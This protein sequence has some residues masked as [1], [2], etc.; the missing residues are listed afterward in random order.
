MNFQKSFEGH[1]GTSRCEAICE[2]V[3]CDIFV[4][5]EEFSLDPLSLQCRPNA[6]S[7]NLVRSIQMQRSCTAFAVGKRRVHRTEWCAVES[8]E[9]MQAEVYEAVQR[10]GVC[11]VESV[12][13]APR[14]QD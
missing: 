13:E 11:S 12:L 9:Q 5:E 3:S 10:A 2:P 6:E 1:V 8:L 7:R 4:L 14:R